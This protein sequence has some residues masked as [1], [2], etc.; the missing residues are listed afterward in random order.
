[1][2]RIDIHPAD[3]DHPG[4]VRALAMM[5]QRTATMRTVVY[6]DLFGA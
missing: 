4:H 6:D 5:V 2:L 1:L 3:F